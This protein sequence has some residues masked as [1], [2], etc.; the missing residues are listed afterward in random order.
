MS[1]TQEEGIFRV[2]ILVHCLSTGVKVFDASMMHPNRGEIT[3]AG[4]TVP[5]AGLKSK[6]CTSSSLLL[7]FHPA[8]PT[9][10]AQVGPPSRSHK[11]SLQEGWRRHTLSSASVQ[12]IEAVAV[13]RDAL[14]D[15][16]S[17]LVASRPE[18]NMQKRNHLGTAEQRWAL[19]CSSDEQAETR[20]NPGEG[21][22]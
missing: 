7:P 11:H 12:A 16:S 22:V 14:R 1:R 13:T 17:S 5:T 19:N 10:Q 18:L 21:T 9:H 15:W 4:G 6:F 8:A 2:S 20:D 3:Q